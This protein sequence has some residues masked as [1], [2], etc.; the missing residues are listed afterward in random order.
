MSEKKAER[1]L[2]LAIALRAVSYLC[3]KLGLGEMGRFTLLMLRFGG[4]FL[5]LV[6][7][8]GRKLKG[9]P[10]RTFVHGAILG[11]L[12][13]GMLS[14]ELTGL[15]TTPSSEASF[16]EN[17][18]IV[19]VPLITAALQQ[20]RPESKTLISAL[21]ALSGVG[22][23]ASRNGGGLVL[24]SGQLVIML[25]SLLYSSAILATAAFSRQDDPLALGILQAGFCGLYAGVAAFT[26]E[27]PA[28]PATALGWGVVLVLVF[29]CTLLGYTL[30]PIA[31]AHTSPETAGLMCA[32]SP[33]VA[34]L[35]GIVFLHEALSIQGMI[36][37]LLI[38]SAMLYSKSARHRKKS[39]V[40]HH[41]PASAD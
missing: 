38:L 34:M 25:A 1:L 27:Q 21:L 15:K 11:G 10:K 29:V 41:Q 20:R 19:W 30:Q 9:C 14:C 36:G 6:L 33:L 39:P 3:N 8:F 40:L 32:L 28:L 13:F 16:L 26:F 37:A 23:L 17:T 22:F 4:A 2:A 7:L 18:A 12:Y 35:L 5:L 24:S 31:Q